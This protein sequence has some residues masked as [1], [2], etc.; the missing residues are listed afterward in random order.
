MLNQKSMLLLNMT[1]ERG[2]L[3]LYYFLGY[4]WDLYLVLLSVVMLISLMYFWCV[5]FDGHLKSQ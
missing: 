4:Y 5:I 2:I 3:I 1:T